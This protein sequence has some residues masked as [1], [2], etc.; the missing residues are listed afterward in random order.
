[1]ERPR[2]SEIIHGDQRDSMT[3]TDC[4]QACADSNFAS[5]AAMTPLRNKNLLLLQ[6]TATRYGFK[7]QK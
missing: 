4:E 2:C 7:Q 3:V 6:G 1:M 5:G